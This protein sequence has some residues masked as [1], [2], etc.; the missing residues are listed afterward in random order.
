MNHLSQFAGQLNC[1]HCDAVISTNDWPLNGDAVPFYFQESPGE[2]S[3]KI[4]CSQCGKAMFV[5]WDDYPGPIEKLEAEE[6][7][8]A[9]SCA[10]PTDA[11]F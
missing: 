1:L 2:Y 11:Q 4:N 6:A 10:P 7:E 9:P 8:T 3:I 5:V